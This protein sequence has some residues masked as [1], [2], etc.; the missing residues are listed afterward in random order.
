MDTTVLE[1]KIRLIVGLGNPGRN[2]DGTRHN[3]GFAVLDAFARHQ[4]ASF[5]FEKKWNAE[6]SKIPGISPDQSDL[7]LMKPK[8]FMNLSGTAVAGYAR[9]FHLEAA[10]TLIVLDDIALPLGAL[11]L[12]RSGSAGGQRGL[13]SVL[14]H[15]STQGV[16]RLKIGIG[17]TDAAPQ[18]YSEASL[19]DYVLSPFRRE[20][21][22]F[23]DKSIQRAVDA[24]DC[25][26]REGLDTAMNFYN[27]IP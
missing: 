22:D 2:Y 25:L 5:S 13:E 8:T 4:G 6:V 19:S 16:P 27:P 17:P 9:F 18:E 3:I 24:L 11:R 7:I 14:T 12:R 15:F 10:Q 26:Q 23:V 20:E 21:Q 1:T